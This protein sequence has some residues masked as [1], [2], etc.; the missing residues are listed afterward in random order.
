MKSLLSCRPSCFAAFVASSLTISPV[1]G[2]TQMLWTS[3]HGDIGVGYEDE[4]GGFAL[5]PHWHIEGGTVDGTPRADEEFEPADLWLIVPDSPSTQATRNANASWAPIGV[6]AGESYWRLSTTSQTGVP[7]LGWATEELDPADW[8]GE[9]SFTLTG[10]TAPGDI[11]VYYFPDGDLTFLWASSDGLGDSFG[12]EAGVH[13]HYNVAFSAPGLY[14]V[15]LTISGTHVTDGF[16]SSTETFT[17][18]IVPE[19]SSALLIAT[20]LGLLAM[21][22]SRRP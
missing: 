8:V 11:S 9:I 4:G 12:L 2:F 3:G 1:T 6:A 13:E 7:Y 21:R 19:P 15:A 18:Q 20:G 14:E 22:R 5:H 16:V 10:L 17:F